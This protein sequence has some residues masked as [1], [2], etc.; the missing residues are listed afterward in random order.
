MLTTQPSHPFPR[1][2]LQLSP[3]VP[4]ALNHT[5]LLIPFLAVCSPHLDKVL[6]KV[7]WSPFPHGSSQDSPFLPPPSPGHCPV[8]ST[9]GCSAQCQTIVRPLSAW[10][11]PFTSR[12]AGA[13]ACLTR[14]QKCAPSHTGNAV[15]NRQA[16]TAGHLYQALS[17]SLPVFLASVLLSFLIC[18][19]GTIIPSPSS[20]FGGREKNGVS[21]G[22]C[23]ELE[24]LL[25]SRQASLA[26]VFGW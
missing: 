24:I 10:P 9:R 15:L 21:L 14:P 22:R 11:A 2:L 25:C 5:P 13:V 18:K 8:L 19:M 1:V 26:E 4:S 3:F 12:T 16:G 23:E 17:P 6:G 7:A 20:S